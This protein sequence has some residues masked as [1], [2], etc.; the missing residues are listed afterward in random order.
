MTRKIYTVLLYRIYL[1]Y[2]KTHYTP[3]LMKMRWKIMNFLHF[4]HERKG[5]EENA[6]LSEG[7][8]SIKYQIH[9][10]L[11]HT[12]ALNYGSIKVSARTT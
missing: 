5:I 1:K 3:I 4:S 10:T 11:T 6:N 12:K 7:V 8:A 9:A 2:I